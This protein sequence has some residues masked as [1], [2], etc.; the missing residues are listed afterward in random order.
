MDEVAY[1]SR[2]KEVKE[3]VKKIEKLRKSKE[4]GEIPILIYGNGLFDYTLGTEDGSEEI[5]N[6][7]HG[8]ELLI[9]ERN[10]KLL[11]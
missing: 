1:F 6:S 10:C 9:P 7:K 11:L 4:N 3:M 2:I 5:W 8:Y